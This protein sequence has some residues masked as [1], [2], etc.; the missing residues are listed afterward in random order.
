[1]NDAVMLHTQ[2]LPLDR[3]QDTEIHLL[4]FQRQDMAALREV[5]GDR[6]Y[7]FMG[8]DFFRWFKP[9]TIQAETRPIQ[10]RALMLCFSS[11]QIHRKSMLAR[12]GSW[13]RARGFC[14]FG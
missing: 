2:V 14:R 1:M 12:T 13:L 11:Q 8:F 10:N 5:H 3:A 4:R 6:Q 9:D 7:F